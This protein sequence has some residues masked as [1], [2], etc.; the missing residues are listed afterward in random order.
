MILFKLF[1]K[2]QKPKKKIIINKQVEKLLLGVKNG[3]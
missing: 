1:V 3:Q 2:N